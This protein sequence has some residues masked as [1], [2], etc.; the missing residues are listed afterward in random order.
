MKNVTTYVTKMNNAISRARNASGKMFNVFNEAYST[1]G[2]EEFEVFKKRISLEKSTINK[3]QKIS[4][5][6][7][8]REN[9]SRLPVSWGTLYV[10]AGMEDLVVLKLLDSSDLTKSSTKKEVLELKQKYSVVAPA[11]TVGANKS[12]KPATTDGGNESCE[13]AKT[14]GG[15]DSCEPV[16]RSNISVFYEP[17]NIVDNERKCIHLTLKSRI[18][19]GNE[20][21][22]RNLI[23]ELSEFFEVEGLDEVFPHELEEAA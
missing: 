5:H 18:N 15:N 3:M 12:C 23:E 21:E 8:I 9:I 22:I 19:K 17:T 1:L 6:K 7:V 16:N 10:L 20:K 13:P 14:T 4:S 2:V 11:K